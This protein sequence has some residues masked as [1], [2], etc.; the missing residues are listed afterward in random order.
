M[1]IIELQELT[2]RFG[3]LTAVDHINLE[4]PE[5]EIFGFLGPNGAGKTT[6]I[7]IINSLSAPTEGYCLVM[8]H[9][10][11]KEP[12]AVRRLIGLV[13]QET[14]LYD[15]L[16]GE[17]NLLFH[18]DL[19]GVP[20]AEIKKRM[21]E[22]LDLMLL[23]DRRHDR[24]GVYSGGMKRRLVLARALLSD[25]QLLIL[26]EPTVGLDPQGMQAIWDRILMLKQQ[27]R[28]ILLA[29]NLMFEADTLCDHL[30]VID[31]GRIIAQ[32]T[33]KELEAQLEGDVI[34]LGLDSL[35]DETLSG[36]RELQAVGRAERSEAASTVR[37]V[38]ESGERALVEAISFLDRRG[39]EVKT[40]E[41]RAPTLSDVFFKLTG[42]GLRD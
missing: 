33:P 34:E 9:D 29:T 8:G 2:K 27:G 16:T 5:N 1:A 20:R 36:L 10:P 26:D 6:T 35:T 23:S 14:A 12:A 11:V 37:I 31:H 3:N 13:S 41:M 4:V 32:G 40:V 38:A 15:Q 30:V 17:E 25:P 42:R 21:D 18:A 28:S 7:N 39:I 24:V 19:Y 22:L